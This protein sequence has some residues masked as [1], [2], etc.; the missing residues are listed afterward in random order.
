MSMP[1]AG[2]VGAMDEDAVI[3][4]EINLELDNINLDDDADN[5]DIDDGLD[6]GEDMPDDQEDVQVSFH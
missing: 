6:G 4:A 1:P 2:M 5:I 3:Q